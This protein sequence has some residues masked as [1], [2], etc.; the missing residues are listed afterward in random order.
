MIRLLLRCFAITAA[1]AAAAEDSAW[2]GDLDAGGD[3]SLR[4]I[5]FV[6]GFAGTAEQYERPAKLFASNGYPATW[7]SGYEYN[8]TGPDGGSE[9]LDA[10]I[11]AVLKRTG[12]DKVDLVGHSRGTMVSQAYLS[13]PTRAAKVAHFA[14]IGGRPANNV[15]GVPTLVVGSTGDK[16]AGPGE[17]TDGAQHAVFE[18]PDHI[19]VA[20]GSEAFA[21][22]YAFFNDGKAPKTNE[23]APSTEIAVAGFAKVFGPNTPV[24]GG[25][26]EVFRVKPEDGSRMTET[27]YYATTVADNGAWG[28]FK[29]EPGAYY[30]FQLHIPGVD[31]PVHYYREPFERT[32]LLVYLKTRDDS[33][34]T[35]KAIAD[36]LHLTDDSSV[37]VVAQL[38]GAVVA[39]RDSLKVNGVELATE[40]IA[41]EDKTKVGFYLFDANDN[42][43]TDAV[44]PEG[45]QWAGPFITAADVYL[46]AADRAAVKIELNGRVLNVPSWKALSEGQ[47]SVQFNG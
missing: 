9:P 27:P 38:N 11:D 33:S 25:T 39:G 15:G 36:A 34:E 31:R 46:P 45:T 20:T 16:L 5:V 7:I 13:D 42:K 14:N 17:A 47:V 44:R 8:S 12:F 19:S 29:A 22:V 40:D 2:T 28:P 37:M 10:F 43:K 6:H 21:A 3:K 4:P 26:I 35:G 24:A 18:K 41:A 30:E 1:L 32:D 23:I